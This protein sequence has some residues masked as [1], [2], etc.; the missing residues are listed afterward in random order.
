MTAQASTLAFSAGVL[1]PAACQHTFSIL[2]TFASPL[3]RLAIPRYVPA[4]LL[5]PLN[6]RF[7]SLRHAIPRCVPAHLLSPLNFRFSSL[8]AC[9]PT[10][11]SLLTFA[12][13]LSRHAIPRC[14][15]A[16]LLSPLNFRFSSLQACYPTLHHAI[17]VLSTSV[18]SFSRC[19][20]THCAASQPPSLR[21]FPSL[22]P[23]SPLLDLHLK[24]RVC[25]ALPCNLAVA[26]VVAA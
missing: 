23:S 11:L 3:S 17:S 4:H 22:A 5:S 10:L 21:H 16:H 18:S 19:A 26:L 15:P 8:Q 9:Y 14:V 7:S 25:P 24:G 2:L 20:M 12:S 6:I 13:P 1:P